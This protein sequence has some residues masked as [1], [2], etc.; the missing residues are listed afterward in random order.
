M[1]NNTEYKS[2]ITNLQSV[3]L[4]LVSIPFILYNTFLY[5]TVWNWFLS[6][7]LFAISYWD[8]LLV[9]VVL[10]FILGSNN[11]GFN[12]ERINKKV[13]FPNLFDKY[14]NIFASAVVRTIGFGILFFLHLI[15]SYYS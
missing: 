4:F 5:T 15:I 10:R 7:K 8:M 11:T 14:S 9:G 3:G 12:I 1:S 13:G 2:D 6:E